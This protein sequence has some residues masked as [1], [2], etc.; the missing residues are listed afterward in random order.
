[1]NPLIENNLSKELVLMIQRINPQ[2][3]NDHKNLDLKL[4]TIKRDLRAFLD[5]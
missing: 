5:E 2:K 3:I 1:M 4:K